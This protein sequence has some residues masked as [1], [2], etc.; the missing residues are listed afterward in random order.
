MLSPPRVTA[1]KRQNVPMVVACGITPLDITP[2]GNCMEASK[3]AD[4]RPLR[5]HPP[6]HTTSGAED[7]LGVPVFPIVTAITPP[8]VSPH[9]KTPPGDKKAKLE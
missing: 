8:S 9:E 4:C 2:P 5:Y 6:Y 3:G 7:M 1:W